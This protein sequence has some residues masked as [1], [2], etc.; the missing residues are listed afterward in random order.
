MAQLAEPNVKRVV[1]ESYALVSVNV[2]YFIPD[3]ENLVNE[4]FWQTLDLHPQ[5]PRVQRFLRFW[6]REID[7][8]IKN[9]TITH[10]PQL[11]SATWRNGIILAMD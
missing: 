5:F 3:H 4:F 6:R 8:R 10:Q 1:Y 11:P 9:V 2:L 7:A